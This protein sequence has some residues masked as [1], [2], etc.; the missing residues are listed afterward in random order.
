MRLAGTALA[1][2]VGADLLSSAVAPGT[3]QVPSDGQPIVLLADAQTIGGYP[4]L[5]HV[6][7]VDLPLLAQLRPGDAMRFQV[8]SL[9]EAHE[10]WLAREQA[11]AM[12]R[13]GLTQKIR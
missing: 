13:L 4:Q 1:R 5:A 7:L 10:R 11:L 6:I 3:V 8:V 9:E 2:T 12:L